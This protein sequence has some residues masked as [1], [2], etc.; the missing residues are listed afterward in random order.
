MRGARWLEILVV[1]DFLTGLL[2]EENARFVRG[3]VRRDGDR[4]AGHDT[5][6]E[7]RG[8]GTIE[9]GMSQLTCWCTVIA[10]SDL[11]NPRLA[12]AGSR[13]VRFAWHALSLLRHYDEVDLRN[14]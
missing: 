14:I 11:F 7:I 8:L 9:E 1:S 6:G 2:S 10:V 13:L 12:L 3:R 5:G 4:K